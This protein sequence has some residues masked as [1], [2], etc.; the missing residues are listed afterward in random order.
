MAPHMTGAVVTLSVVL[1][2]VAEPGHAY[3]AGQRSAVD[4]LVG[5][6]YPAKPAS[7]RSSRHVY[8]SVTVA[9][10]GNLKIRAQL[11]SAPTRYY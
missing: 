11:I 6:K 7:E 10:Q 8:L 4:E 5:Q 1:P 3:P 9:P 2:P